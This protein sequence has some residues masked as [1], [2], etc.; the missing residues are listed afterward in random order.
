MKIEIAERLHPFS[1]VPGTSFVLPGSSL[2]IEIF[3][4][5]LRIKELALGA[6]C[7]VLELALD[8]EGPIN[9]FTALQDLEK[10]SLRVWGT[11]ASGYFRYVVKALESGQGCAVVVEKSPPA[12]ILLK[13]S[14]KWAVRQESLLKPNEKIVFS[15]QGTSESGTIPC[16]FHSIERLSLGSHKLQDWELVR[17]RLTFNEIFP[18]WYRLG[19]MVL[20]PSLNQ[21]AGTAVLLNDCRNAIS[22]KAPEK[23]LAHF[24]NLFLAGFSG[25]L[26]PRLVDTDFQGIRHLGK[27]L[28]LPLETKAS[29]LTLLTEGFQL[30]RSLF[31]KEF[32]S[33]IHL[34]PS[35]PPEF[36]CGRLV[37]VRC[38]KKGSLSLEWTKKSLRCLTFSAL[39]DQQLAFSFSNHEKSCRLRTSYKDKGITYIRGSQIDIIAHQNYWL[40]NFQR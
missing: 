39:E 9:D 7:L 1:H 31:L 36:H 2:A 11:S 21:L 6:P 40:D 8:L 26:S 33:T 37:E 35:M 17:R 27:D 12:G 15:E 19:Q 32:D 14:G 28:F 34:L 24:Q 13:C 30:I 3:P 29:A 25:V 16:S 18:I 38:G 22:G 5:L 10:G 23:I 20:K 4:A